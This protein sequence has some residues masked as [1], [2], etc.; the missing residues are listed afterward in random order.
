MPLR[1]AGIVYEV[2]FLVYICIAYITVLNVVQGVFTAVAMKTSEQDPELLAL[3][4]QIEKQRQEKI[5]KRLFQYLDVDGSS[6]ITLSELE[7]VWHTRDMM[8][9]L[10]A[11]KFNTDDSWLFFSMLDTDGDGLITMKELCSGIEKLTGNSVSVELSRLQLGQKWIIKRLEEALQGVPRGEQGTMLDARTSISD[12]CLRS[13][14][15]L[16]HRLSL[17]SSSGECGSPLEHH[18]SLI[19]A[20]STDRVDR[21]APMD[22]PQQANGCNPKVFRPRSQVRQ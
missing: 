16:P 6:C 13:L 11:L 7:K 9:F 21:A 15:L 14:H 4:T 2:V 12:R 3:S 18:P 10:Q 20:A 22:P 19:S 17:V 8:G 5:S 1:T